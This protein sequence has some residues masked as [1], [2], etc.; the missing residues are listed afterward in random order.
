MPGLRVARNF[1]EASPHVVKV[2]ERS[3]LI[4]QP[5]R[6]GN[7]VARGVAGPHAPKGVKFALSIANRHRE[8]PQLCHKLTVGQHYGRARPRAMKVQPEGFTEQDRVAAI[9]ENHSQRAAE[10]PEAMEEVKVDVGG[11]HS[12]LKTD[13]AAFAA[14][15]DAPKPEPHKMEGETGEMEQ[16]SDQSAQR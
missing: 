15:A 5:N 9:A 7:P 10:I 6:P 8:L 4:T 12:V 3:R 2:P 1:G 16:R 13:S 11:D 14:K